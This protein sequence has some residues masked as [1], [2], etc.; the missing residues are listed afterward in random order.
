MQPNMCL[1]FDSTTYVYAFSEVQLQQKQQKQKQQPPTKN[2][3]W[4]RLLGG[5]NRHEPTKRVSIRKFNATPRVTVVAVSLQDLSFVR[6]CKNI[7]IYIFRSL[8]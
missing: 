5:D 1:S 6:Y 2:R 3:C 7:Y 8:E 4:N